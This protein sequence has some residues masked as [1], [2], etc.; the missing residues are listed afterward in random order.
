MNKFFLRFIG[1]LFNLKMLTENILH[2]CLFNLLK[3]K[4]EERLKSV[5]ELFLRFGKT[6]DTERA[7]VT[8]ILYKKGNECCSVTFLV[9]MTSYSINNW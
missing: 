1:E 2:D 8:M 4:D 9:N 7:K 3:A 5:C 6:L